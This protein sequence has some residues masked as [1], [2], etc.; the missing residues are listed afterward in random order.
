MEAATN[1]VRDA[2]PLARWQIVD[3]G[4]ELDG[5]GETVVGVCDANERKIGGGDSFGRV[6]PERESRAFEFVFTVAE[7]LDVNLG[8]PVPFRF[9]IPLDA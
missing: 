8:D 3:E 5:L 7:A 9:G 2:G 4:R 1:C 6:E